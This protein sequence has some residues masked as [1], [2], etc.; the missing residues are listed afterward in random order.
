[1]LPTL[2]T[3]GIPAAMFVV[4]AAISPS[5]CLPYAPTPPVLAAACQHTL[6]GSTTGSVASP[7]VTELSGISASRL[8]DG[9][10]WVH[11]DS[12]DSARVFAI[13][14]DGR[15]LG[16]YALAGATAIDWEDIEA[17]PG[18][19]AGVSYLYVGDIGDD[20]SSR[21]SIQVY[22][23]P[24]PTVDPAVGP[25]PPQ[26]LTGVARLTL[27]Y[28]DSAHNAEALLVDPT[29]GAM[30]VVTK[31]PSGIAQVFRAPANLAAGTTT[32]LT[33][34]ATVNLGVGG[35]VTAA[36]VTPNG[37]VVALRTYL[38]V[39]L[40]RRSGGAPLEHAFASAL[41]CPGSAPTEVQG[42]ALG[43]TRDGRGYVT[44][45]EGAHPAVHR[46]VAP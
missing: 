4:G 12:G 20:S 16:E 8:V 3:R 45:S 28:P 36:D 40:Y 11:N 13:G 21:A 44:A 33:Q 29:S 5:G 23:V 15:D 39:R 46:F 27:V 25:P 22:R 34:V 10:W 7:A 14:D 38:S 31:E 6:V 17:G 35:A 37:D 30:L 43:F 26:T 42:E 9:V 19:V 41:Q 32:T 24:E 18:P 2:L 1:M